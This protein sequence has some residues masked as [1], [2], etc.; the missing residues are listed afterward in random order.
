MVG[1]AYPHLGSVSVEH[2]RVVGLSVNG[3]EVDNLRVDGVAVLFACL[4]SHTD[5]AVRHKSTLK[6]LVSLETYDGL[7][8]LIEIAGS[9]GYDG[10]RNLR[11]HIKHRPPCSRS[12]LLSSMT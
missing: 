3:K 7:L 6:R 4:D 11:V 9:M 12:S 10:R 2:A 5:T 1:T 8:V